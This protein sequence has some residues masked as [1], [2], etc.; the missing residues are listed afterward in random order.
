MSRP[1]TLSLQGWNAINECEC[2]LRLVPIG[3]GELDGQGNSPSVANQMTLTAEFGSV[4][5]IRACLRPPKTARTELPSTIARDQSICPLRANQ[6][7]NTKW[8][9]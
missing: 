7:R 4:G 9:S 6:S 8:I 2:L 3:T 1:S 5:W